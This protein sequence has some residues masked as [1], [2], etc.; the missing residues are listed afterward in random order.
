[1]LVQL[2]LSLVGTSAYQPSKHNKYWSG[3]FNNKAMVYK[4]KLDAHTREHPLPTQPGANHSTVHQ[5]M[6]ERHRVL[7]RVR[8]F[9]SRLVQKV[10]CTLLPEI[11][12]D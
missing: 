8:L 11:D 6:D 9:A 10:T 4:R 7:R 5:P 1:L 3:W 2:V 12:L